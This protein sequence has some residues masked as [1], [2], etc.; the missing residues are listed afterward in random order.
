MKKVKEF[1]KGRFKE[2][3]GDKVKSEDRRVQKRESTRETYSKAV[4]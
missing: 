3:K 2:R 4:I 1:K